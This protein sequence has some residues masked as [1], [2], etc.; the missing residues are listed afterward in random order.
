MRK[1]HIRYCAIG[2][3]AQEC[4]GYGGAMEK[5]LFAAP[6]IAVVLPSFAKS[7]RDKLEGV[8]QYIRLH[9]PWQVRLI[10]RECDNQT[11]ESI[12]RWRPS[13]II[14]GRLLGKFG[15][16]LDFGVPTVV[17][18]AQ[19]N[20]YSALLKR[21]SFITCDQ[22]LV[23]EAGADYLVRQG[24][25]RLSYLA[26]ALCDWSVERGRLFQA[27]A[28][29]K[30]VFCSLHISPGGR[31]T[32]SA[33]WGVEQD[34]L[35]GW[36][37]GLPKQTAVFVSNDRQAREVLEL[38]QLARLRV[39]SDIAVLGCDNDELLCENTLPSLSSVAP[40]F[41]SCGYQAAELL[42]RLMCKTIRKPLQL[43]YGV[44]R[45]V[46]REST[47][48]LSGADDVRVGWGTD[49]IRL[50]AVRRISVFDIAN[51][52]RV[53]RRMAEILFKKQRGRSIN[54]EIQLV[55]IDRLKSLLLETDK[56]ITV[57]CEQCGYR[58]EAHVKR[59][60]KRMVGLTMSQFRTAQKSV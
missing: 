18:D 40:D 9:T 1:I 2:L 58:N 53:S 25:V 24:F 16:E 10:D 56:P 39:P 50:N 8:F 14:L 13:G 11:V 22:R 36:L 3:P 33:D 30:G 59:L 7:N 47:R 38:C 45:I 48:F 57:L 51:H 12:R 55:R 35:L 27:W 28:E 46:E 6:R 31:G 29:E 17:M 23:A 21:A 26:T 34:S 60:F 41:A 19:R 5:P 42:D 52:M 54:S 4:F 49:F 44:K 15:R 37:K 20:C 43:F 32:R